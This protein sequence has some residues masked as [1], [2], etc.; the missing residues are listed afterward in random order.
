MNDSEPKIKVFEPF[1]AKNERSCPSANFFEKRRKK[2]LTNGLWCDSI[3]K[4]SRE[5]NKISHKL[6]R[7]DRISGKIKEFGSKVKRVNSLRWPEKSSWQLEASVVEFIRSANGWQ[8]LPK[9]LKKFWKK[10][11]TN[12][13]R[14]D[15]IIWLT[16][17]AESYELYLVNWIT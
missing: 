8:E 6:W 2:V 3:S 9:K 17:R 15:K 10:C 13:K 14:H 11:L 7:L 1:W 4:R 5:R 12:A 16:A